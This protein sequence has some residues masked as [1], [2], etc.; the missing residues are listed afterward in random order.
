MEMAVEL[1]KKIL[2]K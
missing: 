2:W 1:Q